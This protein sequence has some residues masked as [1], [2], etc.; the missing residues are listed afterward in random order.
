MKAYKSIIFLFVMLLLAGGVSWFSYL[1][2]KESFSPINFNPKIIQKTQQL[3]KIIHLHGAFFIFKKDIFLNNGL[4][5][6]T[7]N[8]FFYDVKFPENLD[9]DNYEDF[10]MARKII[11]KEFT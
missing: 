5:R 2:N 4:Q 6:I 7:K 1:K 10:I 9:L 11:K 8:N 3:N